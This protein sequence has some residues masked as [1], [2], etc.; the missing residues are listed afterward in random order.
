MSDE[1]IDIV[2]E[3]DTLT[4]EQKMKSIAHA[5]GSWHRVTHNWIYNSQN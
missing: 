1:L 2:D 4:G 5:D 3:N